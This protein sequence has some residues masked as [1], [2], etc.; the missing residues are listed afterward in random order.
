MFVAKF[1]LKDN[2][3]YLLLE[4]INPSLLEAESQTVLKS[5]HL[6]MQSLLPIFK[7][8]NKTKIAIVTSMSAIR[9]YSLGATHCA[10]KGAIDRYTNSAMLELYKDNIFVTTIRPGAVDTGMYDGKKVQ[11]AVINISDQFNGIYKERF[12][13]APPVSVGTIVA[14][15]LSSKGHI[16]SINLVAEG[17]L[18]HEGS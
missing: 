3:P 15:S 17:Q 1:K 13:L 18:P 4:E 9:G 8:Q 7:K 2:N 6:M 12:C 16:T 14:N 10:A 5:T 11:E